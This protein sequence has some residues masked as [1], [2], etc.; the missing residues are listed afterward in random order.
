VTP[1]VIFVNVPIVVDKVFVACVVRRVD[2][3]AFDS[4][5][6]GHPKVPKSIEVVPFND[7]ILPRGCA[8][9]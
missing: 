9:G 2:I 1:E 8:A 4:S 7:E 6:K 3:D 5:S